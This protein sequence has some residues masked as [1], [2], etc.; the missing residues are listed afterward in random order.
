MRKIIRGA[1]SVLISACV[2]AGA[3]AAV[4]APAFADV[5]EDNWAY[6]YVSEAAEKGWVSGIGGGLFAPDNEV[7]YAELSTMLVRAFFP[8]ELSEHEAAE[9]ELWY[10]AACASAETLDLYVGVDIRTQ[11]TNESMVTQPVSRYEMAQI[12]YNTL[13]AAEVQLT[14]DLAAAQATTGDWNSVPG[15]YQA[16]VAA[17]KAAGIIAGV[18]GAG[19]FNG[20]ATMS[21]AQAATV[22][23]R[24]EDV[25][26]NGLNVPPAANENEGTEGSENADSSSA[27]ENQNYEQP[28]VPNE[29]LADD[30][31]IEG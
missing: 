2:T 21:R 5:P 14:P 18:D 17:M 10:T 4:A 15:R 30:Q 11:H 8:E 23:C 13:R 6:P 31:A 27:S 16:A 3:A 26:V 1:L 12:L 29:P 22:M 7:T 28:V 19:T 24:M 25:L 9:D 20:T